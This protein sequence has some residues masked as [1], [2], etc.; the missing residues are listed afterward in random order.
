[1]L[2]S[3]DALKESWEARRK[4]LEGKMAQIQMQMQY[5]YNVQQEGARL[6]GVCQPISLHGSSI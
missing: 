2:G 1:M 4:E 3:F 6:Q 5:G